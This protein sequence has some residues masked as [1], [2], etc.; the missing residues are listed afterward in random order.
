MAKLT[1][2]LIERRRAHHTSFAAALKRRYDVISVTSGSQAL[3]QA[4]D[5]AIS[6]VVL[7]AVS[8]QS[9]GTRITKQLKSSLPTIPLVHLVAEATESSADVVLAA[10]ITTRKLI[11]TVERL[12][13]QSP[14]DEIIVCGPFMMRP[15]Q[16]VL[17]VNGQETELTP[18]LAV[19]VEQFLRNPGVTLDR[20][21][22]ME[23]V[24]KTDYLGDTRTLDVHIRWFRRAIEADPGR[25]VYLKTV[26]GV[27]YRLEIASPDGS[28][29]VIRERALQ[30][31]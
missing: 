24:W 11:N 26:R 12:I 8:M 30:P 13:H 28:A 23:K 18:K 6:V 2:L 16:R 14:E 31:V 20:K 9:P 22:L 10:P 5:H 19:L 4:R 7:D 15:E 3:E 29:A 27:G 21:S 17:V 25:P 1:V